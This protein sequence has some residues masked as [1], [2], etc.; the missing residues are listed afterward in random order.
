MKGNERLNDDIGKRN[1]ATEAEKKE[2]TDWSDSAVYSKKRKIFA[3]SLS[4][5]QENDADF[6]KK[7]PLMKSTHK[8]PKKEGMIFPC[9]KNLKAKIKMKV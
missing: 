7:I 6:Q 4:E 1:E 9:P 2:N 3:G 5:R 8:T